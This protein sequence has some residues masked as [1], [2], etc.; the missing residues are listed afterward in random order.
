[1]NQVGLRGGILKQETLGVYARGG[2]DQEP[3]LGQGA[4]Q[5]RQRRKP[6]GAVNG[7]ANY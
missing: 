4:A 6:Q 1:M 5:R 3:C 2:F 7:L